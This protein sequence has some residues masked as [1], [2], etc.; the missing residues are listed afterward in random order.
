MVNDRAHSPRQSAHDRRDIEQ[1]PHDHGDLDKVQDRHGK[2]PTER[3]VG[4]HNRGADYDADRLTD[5]ALGHHVEYQPQHFE[6][7]RNP[8]QVRRDHA[9]GAEDFNAAVIANPIVIADGQQIE[10]IETRGEKESGENQTHAR[11][12]WIGHDATQ[13]LFRERGRNPEHRFCAEPRRK[14]RRRHNRQRKTPTGNREILRGM[15]PPGGNQPNPD[16]Q[17]Q[18]EYDESKNHRNGLGILVGGF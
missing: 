9:E 1:P 11:P 17:K 2:H 18:I 13:S 3:R 7:G 6:L 8:A 14:D 12:E 4:Q 10:S 15:D 16:R 5:P